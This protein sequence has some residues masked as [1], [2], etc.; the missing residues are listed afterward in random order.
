MLVQLTGLL[1]SLNFFVLHEIFK[2][3]FSFKNCMFGL[4]PEHDVHEEPLPG[5]QDDNAEQEQ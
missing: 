3:T 4:V 1:K 5:R 2:K